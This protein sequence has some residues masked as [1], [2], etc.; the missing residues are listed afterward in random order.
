[1]KKI[2]FVVDDDEVDIMAIKRALKEMV[3]ENEIALETYNDGEEIICKLK[4]LSLDGG[5]DFSSIPFM[6][7]L[8][9]N[10]PRVSGFE[11]IDHIRKDSNLK[12]MLVFVLTT[13]S[14]PLD[15]SKAYQQNVAGYLV[16]SEQGNRYEKLRDLVQSY[17]K[18][19]VPPPVS[20]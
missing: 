5:T 1:M 6:I 9:L 16:K 19:V 20:N 12:S 11:V 3:Q 14:N 7:F 4:A 8:D 13:S 10:M 17:C 2:I 15:I 18:A